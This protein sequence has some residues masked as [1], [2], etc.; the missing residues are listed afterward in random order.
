MLAT[1]HAKN[2]EVV[3]A[4]KKKATAVKKAPTKSEILAHISE[5]TGLTRKEVSS[6][7]E[8]L[9]GFMGNCGLLRIKLAF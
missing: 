8:N 1:G 7:F 5:K 6:V 9:E 2:G 3:M 4:A